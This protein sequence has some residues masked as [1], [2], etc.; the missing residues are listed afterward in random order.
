MYDENLSIL[1]GADYN[2]DVFWLEGTSE[3][4]FNIT[5][6]Q[7]LDLVSIDRT[8]SL[9]KQLSENLDESY[10]AVRDAAYNAAQAIDKF[11]RLFNKTMEEY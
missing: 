6:E 2:A 10:S 3:D 9:I 4:P 11:I 8:A 1:E 7:E 5:I